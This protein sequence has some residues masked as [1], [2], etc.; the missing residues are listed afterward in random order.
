MPAPAR[1]E[2]SSLV[3]RLNASVQLQQPNS[4]LRLDKY[5]R[6]ADLLVRQVGRSRCRVLDLAGLWRGIGV[7][8]RI[9]CS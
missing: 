2:G 5:F 8:C 7:C 9:Y 6:S 4:L 3:S 1:R